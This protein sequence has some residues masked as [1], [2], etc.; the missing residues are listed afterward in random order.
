MNSP[1]EIWQNQTAE[2]N[3][4][5]LKLIEWKARELRTKT[6]KQWLGMFV[7]PLTTAFLY[8]LARKVF[9]PLGGLTESLFVAAIVWSLAGLYFL[10]RGM[11]SRTP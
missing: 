6:R 7:M 10:S 3:A 8:G 4:M 5:T 11:R 9:T 1:Q 2:R